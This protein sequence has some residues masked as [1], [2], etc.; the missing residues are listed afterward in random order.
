MSSTWH[1][2]CSCRNCFPNIGRWPLLRIWLDSFQGYI[3]KMER[4]VLEI[5]AGFRRL[6]DCRDFT[7]LG[8]QHIWKTNNLPPL[9]CCSLLLWLSFTTLQASVPSI[10]FH[11]LSTECTIPFMHA[12]L[13]LNLATFFM[14]VVFTNRSRLTLFTF[15]VSA[16][17]CGHSYFLCNWPCV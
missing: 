1:T 17:S 8:L 13:F 9:C 5:A 12:L 2:C 15:I 7:H 6:P 3:K 14:T 16:C 11:S 4:M 10:Q